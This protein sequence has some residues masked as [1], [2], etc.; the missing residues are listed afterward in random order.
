MNGHKWAQSGH[1]VKVISC[2]YVDIKGIS[3]TAYH[4]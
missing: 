3:K 4:L 2:E 1:K